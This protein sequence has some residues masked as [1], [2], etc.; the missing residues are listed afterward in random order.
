M[1]FNRAASPVAY[2]QGGYEMGRVDI[3]LKFGTVRQDEF[4][5]SYSVWWL[6]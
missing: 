3:G 2:G 1:P 6:F 4:E 5:W